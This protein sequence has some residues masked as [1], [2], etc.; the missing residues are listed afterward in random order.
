MMRERRL[1]N[2]SGFAIIIFVKSKNGGIAQLGAQ[3]KRLRTPHLLN[4]NLI[5]YN[6]LVYPPYGGIAQLGERLN[7]IQ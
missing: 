1:T 2:A 3:L 7:G 5:R 6:Y 4:N